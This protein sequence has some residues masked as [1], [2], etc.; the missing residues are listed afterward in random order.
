MKR[1]G[2]LLVVGVVLERESMTTSRRSSVAV[3][4]LLESV[5]TRLSEGLAGLDRH[6]FY[7]FRTLPQKIEKVNESQQNL[8]LTPSRVRIGPVGEINKNSGSVARVGVW[9]SVQHR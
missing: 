5:L 2:A 4:V 8:E 1:L 6:L 9:R 7:V 3:R